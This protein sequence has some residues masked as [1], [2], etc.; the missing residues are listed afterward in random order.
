MSD[1]PRRLPHLHE[2]LQRL[3][4]HLRAV[5]PLDPDQLERLADLL[6][7]LFG[8]NPEYPVRA[9][10]E[11]QTI[12]LHSLDDSTHHLA[13]EARRRPAPPE[14]NA[15][16]LQALVARLLV[17]ANLRSRHQRA[18]ARLY[19]WGYSLPEIAG[20]LGVPRTTV[21]SRWRRAR[22]RLQRAAAELARDGWLARAGST[23]AIDAEQVAQAFRAEQQRQ[24]YVPPRHCPPGRE[25]CR[26]TGICPF[27]PT[28]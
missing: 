23:D 25:R 1:D 17:A 11:H 27:R 3:R 2:I 7:R 5:G 22:E 28:S 13:R 12:E 9:A 19:L 18:V 26:R 6:L 8:G 10:L 14:A 21:A 20:I 15:A 16:S 24:R 4:A